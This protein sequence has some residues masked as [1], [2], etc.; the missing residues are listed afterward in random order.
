MVGRLVMYSELGM[1]VSILLSLQIPF[2]A[3]I[4]IVSSS[5]RSA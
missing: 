5:S 2:Q 1:V 3:W 4:L